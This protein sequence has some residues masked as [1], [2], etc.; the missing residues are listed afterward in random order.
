MRIA[1][2]IIAAMAVACAR[3]L[4][5]A[6]PNAWLEL[7]TE[8]FTL[9]TDLEE[10]DARRAVDDLELIRS[11][12]LA[13]GWHGETTSPARI[14][15]VALASGRELREIVPE[16]VEG[17]AGSDRFGQ[18][19]ILVSADGNL[20]GSE[21]V[22]HEVAHALL[23]E[24]LVTHPRWVSEGIAC[25]LETLDIDRKN[26]VALRG[27]S[28]WQR[29]DWL[30]RDKGRFHNWSV[31]VMGSGAGFDNANGYEFETL[32]WTL[33]HWLVDSRPTN[34]ETF[35]RG[36]SRG[37]GMWAAFSAAFPGLTE[38]K[39]AAE[40]K[41]Y[42]RYPYPMG[43]QRFPVKPWTGAVASRRLPPAEA[44][45]VRA[46]LFAVFGELPN[47][48]TK[49]QDELVLGR[50]LDAANPLLLAL[51]RNR[52]DLK[53]A[54]DRHPEDWR[55]WELWFDENE[56]DVAAIR[57]ARDLA[58]DNAGVLA[59][60][61][62]AEQAEGKSGLALELAQRAVAI[63]PGPFEL[64]ALATVHEK[65]GRCAEALSEAERAVDALPDRVDARIPGVLRERITHI[66]ASCGKN[67]AIGTAATVD[68]EPVLKGCRQPIRAFP[69]ASSITVQFTIRDD[70]SVTAVAVGGAYDDRD[71]GLLRQFVESC[72]FE[73]VLI[74]GKPHRVQLNLT[75]DAFMH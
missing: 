49:M 74:D 39:L 4:R 3:E 73:P 60:L 32:S 50:A 52:R 71:A 63:S 17:V 24:Y 14:G 2:V 20:L 48:Q 36:L 11:A 62:V 5:S 35:L 45:A 7:E 54:I 47:R 23:H 61:A 69:T 75:L 15:V 37:Q 58:P 22:K 70:G 1:A 12:L 40:M 33:V 26:G 21:T 10:E 51:A 28:H 8:H 43:K 57:R 25:F 68:A 65:D 46:Q 41:G 29:R 42:L 30:E 66:T 27:Q 34:F 6:N 44:H 13:T 64:H 38:E 31:E 9:R 18:R 19:L 55:S 56:Q 53:L 59:R 16:L 72:S 67:D